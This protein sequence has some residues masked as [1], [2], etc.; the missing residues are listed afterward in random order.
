MPSVL[1]MTNE[2]R[3][4]AIHELI[5]IYSSGRLDQRPYFGIVAAGRA[6][7][8]DYRRAMASGDVKRQALASVALKAFYGCVVKHDFDVTIYGKYYAALTV[9]SGRLNETIKEIARSRRT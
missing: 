2:N 9:K 3:C 8:M 4:A 5:G 7:V 1:S 6:V